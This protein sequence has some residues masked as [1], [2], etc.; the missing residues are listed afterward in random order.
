ME[1]GARVLDSRM[2]KGRGDRRPE[3]QACDPRLDV[4]TEKLTIPLA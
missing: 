2:V 4:T 3:F 1:N